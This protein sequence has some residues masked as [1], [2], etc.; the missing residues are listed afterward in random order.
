MT[1]NTLF[2]P[3]LASF[4]VFAIST[5]I[6]L[7]QTALIK[8]AQAADGDL[9]IDLTVR[10]LSTNGYYYS[11]YNDTT[12]AN[13]R[14]RV[15][16]KINV[17]N[18]GN[19]II[20]NARVSANLPSDLGFV[21]GS[22]RV[23]GSYVSDGLTNNGIYIGTLYPGY[24]REVLFEATVADHGSGYSN[25]TLTAYAY[26]RADQLS[27]KNDSATVYASSSNNSPY[28]PYYPSLYLNIYS[29]VRNMTS[30]E[31]ALNSS[32]HAKA[33]DK[34]MFTVQLTSTGSS[35]I[36]NVRIWSILPSGLIFTNG[37]ARIDSN[38]SV[39]DSIVSGGVYIGTIFGAQT[40]TIT[41]EATV[42]SNL[43]NQ[44]LTNYSYMSGDGVPQQSAFSQVIIG[45]GYYS[46]SPTPT[47]S[48]YPSYSPSS[49]PLPWPARYTNTPTP[50]VKGIAVRAI[51]GSNS[52][53][54]TAGLALTLA[55]L[56][57]MA[58]YAGMEYPEFWRKLNL[59]AQILK[60]RIRENI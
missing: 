15:Q 23:E 40:K 45:N 57:I 11:P 10:N 49:S 48:P 5:G 6:I 21:S 13:A 30:G 43:A 19:F 54:Q 58:I 16:F 39:A 53:T 34:L 59:R 47:Y 14:D 26:V 35:Q 33:G 55:I 7:S 28:Y 52:L 20:Y 25:Q 24:N 38:T 1:K 51:T 12:S 4:L 32:V 27:E 3:I 2:K 36:N 18:N 56:A 41:Y 60:I 29:Y 9:T 37:S 42:N 31:G 46:P 17:R 50:T 22:T 8:P 44:T